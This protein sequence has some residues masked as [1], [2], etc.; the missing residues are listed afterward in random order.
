M[1]RWTNAV[2]DELRLIAKALQRANQLQET[3][4]RSRHLPVP[5]ED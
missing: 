3:Y 1:D 4:L 2:L 5:A